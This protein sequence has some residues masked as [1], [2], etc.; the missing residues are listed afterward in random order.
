M[1]DLDDIKR[2]LELQGGDLVIKSIDNLP[3]QLEQSFK[4]SYNIS[5][6]EDFKTVNRIVVCGQGGSRFPSFIIKE[7]FKEELA[8]PYIIN[9]D[10]SLPGFVDNNT[11]VILSSYSGTTEEVLICGEKAVKKG[12]KIC[13]ITIGG[14]L[15]TFLEKNNYPRYV[16]DPV[17][18]PSGQPRIGFG[19]FV[20]GHLGMLFKLGFIK[21]A[22]QEI[23]QSIS[24]LSNLIKD[25][26]VDIGKDN[27]QI[28]QLATKLYQRYPYYIVSEFL[29]GIGNSIANQTNETA[30]SISSFR[31]IPELNHHFL[32]GLK[33]PDKL[34]EILTFVFFYSNLYSTKIQKRFAITKDVVEQN[35][36]ST[37]WYEL[38]GKNKIEQTFELMAIGSYLSMYL[39]VLYE[40]NPK[41]IPYVD[42]FKKRLAE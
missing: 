22:R 5:F 19:Y 14:D 16:I 35:K 29:T 20:G 34:K 41:I 31:I 6:P 36:I 12:A 3:R 42:Y 30:K 40:Q 28:K 13:G 23:E 25:F 15:K 21:S 17:F 2:I 37:L 38:K 11:L 27:N 7:L 8:V 39:S 4:D 24:N 10:Y 1:I 9:D 33:F 18:N 32:E 26:K